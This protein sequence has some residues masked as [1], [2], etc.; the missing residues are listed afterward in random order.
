MRTAA[1]IFG[2]LAG[3]LGGIMIAFGNFEAGL[4]S[5][6]D[7]GARGELVA[8][9]ILFA[10]PG[11]G[12]LGAGLTIS[13]PRL[14]ASFMLLSAAAWL[15]VALVAGHGAVLFGALP[16][17]FV[18]AGGFVALFAPGRTDAAEGDPDL[19]PARRSDRHWQTAEDAP[20]DR[21]YLPAPL[22]IRGRTE[23]D[24][25][26]APPRRSPR[27]GEPVMQRYRAAPE[28]EEAEHIDYDE[29][30]GVD[31]EL[32][33][34]QDYEDQDYVDADP[35]FDPEPETAADHGYEVE[36]EEPD[37]A[38]EVEEPR[39]APPPRRGQR[40]DEWSLPDP[41]NQP[42]RRQLP[43][44][45]VPERLPSPPT[46]HEPLPPRGETRPGRRPPP[47]ENEDP[48]ARND[49]QPRRQQLRQ[50]DHNDY[51]GDFEEDTGREP[52]G[53]PLRLVL[54]L[55]LALLFVLLV[56]G[57]AVWVVLDYQRGPQSLLF[58]NRTHHVSAP[59]STPAPP[60]VAAPPVDASPDVPA[61]A[62][63]ESN[64]VTPLASAAGMAASVSDAG[65]PDVTPDAAP[66]DAPLPLATQLAG[67]FATAS[68]AGLSDPFVYCQAVDTIDAPDD[69]YAGPALP[70]AVAS[71]LDLDSA[72]PAGQV[73][74]RCAGQQVL[75]CNANHTAACEL[76]PTVDLMMSYCRKH[77]DAQGIPA[78][79]GFW[80]CDGSRPSIPSDQR[81]PVDARGFFPQ[82]W[83]R[84]SAGGAVN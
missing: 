46:R 40:F 68:P 55:T 31:E 64:A 59:N 1:L 10:I 6:L 53:G 3:L 62:E 58:G 7:L 48:P 34:D 42:P 30:A 71:A 20:D 5:A 61:A 33:E 72:P 70:A 76:T 50:R 63:P 21:R 2:L 44:R 24:F 51:Y 54:R 38:P 75:A 81:W 56:G 37:Y 14:G 8:R 80:S 83:I 27:S 39:V 15:G 16:F 17:T 69:R 22:A 19:G 73:R 25:A 82:A 23:P 74:W 57:L 49:Y 41:R 9:F 45:H 52:G 18:G 13:L 65:R 43:P 28:P 4:A 29:Q 60:P 36:P 79:N 67:D 35:A 11:I 32:T 26:L 47:A 12:L 78:P 84:V 66:S 77:P